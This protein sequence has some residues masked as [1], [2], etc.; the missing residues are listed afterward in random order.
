M[1][2][3]AIALCA[4]AGGALMGA[5][6]NSIL[7]SRRAK[8]ELERADTHELLDRVQKLETFKARL[9]G[10]DDYERNHHP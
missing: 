6:A 7:E 9:E 10:R 8:R 5:L 3:L 2:S 1:G 4:A